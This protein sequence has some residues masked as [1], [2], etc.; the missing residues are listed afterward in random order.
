MGEKWVS[1]VPV[2][3][4]LLK[5]L[6]LKNENILNEIF[7]NWPLNYNELIVL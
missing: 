4:S 5:Y 1:D 7:V 6:E 3:W 2:S